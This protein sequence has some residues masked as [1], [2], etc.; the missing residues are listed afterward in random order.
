MKT[1]ADIEKRL[2]KLRERYARKYI[3]ASQQRRYENCAYN[4]KHV[5]SPIPSSPARAAPLVYHMAPSR[6]VTLVVLR[7]DKPIH[8]C[9]YGSDDP[10]K[11]RGDIC[12][13]DDVA[14]SC[15]LFRPLVSVDQAKQEFLNL[16][17]DDEYVFNN[18]RDIATLQ[19]VLGERV[20]V[21]PLTLWERIRFWIR[22]KFLKPRKEVPA[23]PPGD[24][25]DNLWDD[26]VRSTTHAP[27]PLSSGRGDEP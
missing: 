21:I 6:Q 15:K 11:W 5:P 19:W 1:K 3:E 17:A 7:E 16:M 22:S 20:H 14:Q 27:P 23:L 2:R 24:L 25:P 8:L 26:S 18:Y 10:S 13:S 4:H 9:M 12:D